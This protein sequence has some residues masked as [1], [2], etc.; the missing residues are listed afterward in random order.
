V[1]LAAALL[2]AHCA[3]AAEEAAGGEAGSEAG[4]EA[5]EEHVSG[6]N[7]GMSLMLLGC[8]GFG[9]SLFYLVKQEDPDMVKYSWQVI[10]S[11]ISIFVAVLLFQAFNGV[12]EQWSEKGSVMRDLAVAL[13]QMLLWFLALQVTLLGISHLS[14]DYEEGKV[15]TE[16]MELNLKC[17]ATLF[18]HI[19]GFAAIN[20]FVIVQEHMCNTQP[21]GWR[22]LLTATC[23]PAM[24]W[25]FLYV[26]ERGAKMVRQKLAKEDKPQTE[27]ADEIWEDLTEETEDDIVGLAVSFL[28]VQS[29]RYGIGGDLPNREGEEPEALL[30]SHDGVE[31]LLL[32]GFAMV[33]ALF[34]LIRRRV[35]C[36]RK[37]CGR[38]APQIGNVSAMSFAWCLYVTA[39]WIVSGTFKEE[40]S[41]ME[42]E[43]V[44][45]LLVTC[46]A[47][48]MIFV[49]DKIAD[50]E[51]TD[52]DLD[53]AIRA[54]VYALAILIGFSWEKAFDVAVHSISEKVTV[55]PQLMTKIILALILAS[56]VIPAWRMHILPTILR[57]EH[58]EK[59]EEAAAHHSDGDDDTEEALLSE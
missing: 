45:A 16:R 52:K 31:T 4:G 46:V 43:T 2:A 58:A 5:E 20:A 21:H 19:T 51:A 41:G 59:A 1:L 22:R 27:E 28:L 34:V 26:L 18:G 8:I 9:M 17:W 55:L 6:M 12:V 15:D 3:L 13:L 33:F 32:F 37:R 57:L 56:V 10:S 39:L 23:V 24:A 38:L 47:L 11:T 54:E 53:Q 30:I 42:K 25:A 35:G 36:I 50:S 44:I 48:G 49:L 14:V 7:F 40:L 29:I